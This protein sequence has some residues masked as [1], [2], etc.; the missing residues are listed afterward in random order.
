MMKSRKDK[1]TPN[2]KSLRHSIENTPSAPNYMSHPNSAIA[3]NAMTKLT[4]EQKQSAK[5][6]MIDDEPIVLNLFE[7]FLAEAGFKK[8]FP[9]TD[10]AEAIETLRFV[11]PSII[12][13]DI[14]MPEVSGSFLIKL[15]R[16]FEHL[17]TVPILA[18][19]SN[20]SEQDREIILRKGA[21][22]VIHKPV[23]DSELVD[24]VSLMLGST[25]RL[26]DRLSEADEIEQQRVNKKKAE[27]M[28]VESSLRDM[29]R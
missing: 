27:M 5:I 23:D 9:F 12:L 24:K 13:T 19:T 6:F 21:D 22:A 11:T 20:T 26:K 25:L 14:N 16:T 3:L 4:N 17:R 8:I 10:S 7:A 28:S 29:M 15:I 1:P 2:K 18:V